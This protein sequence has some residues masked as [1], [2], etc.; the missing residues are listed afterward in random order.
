MSYKTFSELRD[1]V[2]VT[3]HLVRRLLPFIV[4]TKDNLDGK[5]VKFL[6]LVILTVT[7]TNAKMTCEF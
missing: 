1:K 7:L 3:E 6:G 5:V 4:K 2:F